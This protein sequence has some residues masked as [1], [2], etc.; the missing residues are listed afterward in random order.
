M[1]KTLQSLQKENLV[2]IKE[3]QKSPSRHLKR[4]TRIQRGSKTLGFYLDNEI[5]NNLI[6]DFEALQN[7]NYIKSIF[8]ARR[9][10]KSYSLSDVKKRYGI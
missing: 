9:Q 10:K 2:N 1:L 8:K 4:I 3:L 6:E 7:P 5:F